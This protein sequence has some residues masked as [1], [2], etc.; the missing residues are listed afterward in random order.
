MSHET[1]ALAGPGPWMPLVCSK[2]SPSLSPSSPSRAQA[3]SMPPVAFRGGLFL[4]G[5]YTGGRFLF[6]FLLVH[7]VH[8]PKGLRETARAHDLFGSAGRS[9][10]RRHDGITRSCSAEQNEQVAAAGSLLKT[11]TLSLHS[12]S[13]PQKHLT[14]NHDEPHLRSTQLANHPAIA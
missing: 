11:T 13:C 10:G 1:K 9:R 7:P 3:A 2:S 5:V 12:R 6:V 4:F 8:R 14:W